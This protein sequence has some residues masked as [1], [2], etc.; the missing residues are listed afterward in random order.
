MLITTDLHESKCVYPGVSV[1]EVDLWIGCTQMPKK[2]KHY[3][4]QGIRWVF[5]AV[6]FLRRSVEANGSCRLEYSLQTSGILL[7]VVS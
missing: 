5:S 6:F 4:E 2:P 1:D 3:V 7:F